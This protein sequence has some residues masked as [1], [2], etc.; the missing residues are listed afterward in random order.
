MDAVD[1]QIV[2]IG[3]GGVVGGRRNHT[4]GV[5]TEK[6]GRI[7]CIFSWFVNNF[8]IIGHQS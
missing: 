6:V 2:D 1:A 7:F 5:T 4:V 3:F 8:A